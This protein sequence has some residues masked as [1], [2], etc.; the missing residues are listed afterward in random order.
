MT[1][2]HAN[3]TRTTYRDRRGWLIAFGVFE[4]LFAIFCTFIILVV[5]AVFTLPQFRNSNSQQNAT[6]AA[7]LVSA[8][9]V[10]GSMA[11]VFLTIGIGS[12]RCRNWARIAMIVVSGF[13]LVVGVI[14]TL[15]IAFLFP[16]IL[17]QQNGVSAQAAHN[18][19]IVMTGLMGALMVALPSL[20][21]FFYTRPS[22]RDTCL[23]RKTGKTH[24]ASLPQ[25]TPI[26][27]LPGVPAP[28]IVLAV[29]QGLGVF[30]VLGYFKYHS[31]F[32]FG[33]VLHGLPAF[34]VLFSLTALS[35][36]A[37]WAIYRRQAE[38]WFLALTLALFSL[39][40]NVATFAGRDMLQVCREM[41]MREEQIQVLYT[42]PQ[43]RWII[44]IS[45]VPV[46]TAYLALLVYTWKFFS[47]PPAV[48]GRTT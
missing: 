25:L 32:V 36:Y 26:V 11:A 9:V 47:P 34:S 7:G 30:S 22:V 31:T 3:P 2:D 46:T 6:Q 15:V 1:A 45:A 29:W 16:E 5:V 33:V 21:L 18:M 17:R 43:L 13:W 37:A 38:G 40:S 14:T 23:A 8:I 41:G 19:V 27:K 44:W 12:V 39:A 20:L 24:T 4:I 42:F 10:Y 48:T 28:I 35:S